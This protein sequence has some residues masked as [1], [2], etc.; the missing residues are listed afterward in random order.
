MAH[1]DGMLGT[2]ERRG[3]TLIIVAGI[4][5]AITAS[6]SALGIVS[7]V[8]TD[9]F[10]LSIAP[11]AFL[12]LFVGVV[13]MYPNLVERTPRLTRAG[14]GLGV[15][16]LVFAPVLGIV[17]L[18]DLT[19]LL[20]GDIPV[21][22]LGLHLLGRLV[23]LIALILFSAA[24]LRTDAYSR[25]VGFLLLGPA[26]IMLLSF[27]HIGIGAPQW[28]APPL[29]AANGLLMLALGYVLRTD[30]TTTERARSPT[31]APG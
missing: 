10:E 30:S 3:P 13:G 15:L 5:T 9:P 31:D 27:V 28:S 19:G 17:A 6:L 21:W 2:L 8:T 20:P 14:A 11:F 29:V 4:L 23:G 1:G 25:R 16:A 18:A 7:D 26:T 22:A 24:V 12:L